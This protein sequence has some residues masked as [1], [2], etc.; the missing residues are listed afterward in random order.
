VERARSADQLYQQD[1]EREQR[2]S[3][4]RGL[5][6]LALLALIF[7][8]ARAGLHRVFVPGWWRL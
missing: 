4:L 7:S 2:R 5:L 8:V 6:W 1:R 3:L